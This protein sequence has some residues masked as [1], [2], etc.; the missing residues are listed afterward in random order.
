MGNIVIPQNVNIFQSHY[1]IIYPTGFENRDHIRC[2]YLFKASLLTTAKDR[3]N[4]C[5]M[6][7][8]AWINE[9]CCTPKTENCLA[10]KKKE[11][12]MYYKI[13]VP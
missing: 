8:D 3:R 4:S 11:D 13:C 1:G 12:D 6:S 2:V 5:C 7:T 10:F 9:M